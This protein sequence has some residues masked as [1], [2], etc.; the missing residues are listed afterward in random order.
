MLYVVF[1]FY[2]VSI[3]CLKVQKVLVIL[4]VSKSYDEIVVFLYFLLKN[5][6]VIV[7][8]IVVG[9]EYSLG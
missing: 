8:I 3:L 5:Y 7:F 4:I 1:I 9:S 2:N 6:N